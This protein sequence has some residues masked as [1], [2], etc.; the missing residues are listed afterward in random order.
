MRSPLLY[1]AKSLHMD[2][3][4]R[5][6]RAMLDGGFLSTMYSMIDVAMLNPYLRVGRVSQDY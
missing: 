3:L 6:R 5:T 4:A 2:P 1:T